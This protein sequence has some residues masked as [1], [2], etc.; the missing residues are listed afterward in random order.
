V[1]N[2]EDDPVI[3]AIHKGIKRDI[4]IALNNKCLRAAVI[5]IYAGMDAMGFLDLPETQS[6]VERK[7]FISWAGRY[8]GKLPSESAEKLHF[9][10]SIS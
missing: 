3:N 1:V 8:V 5:L 6:E 9:Q 7:D 10:R 4:E 2:L